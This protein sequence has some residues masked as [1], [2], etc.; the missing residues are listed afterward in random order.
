MGWKEPLT[1]ESDHEPLIAKLPPKQ[2]FIFL[3]FSWR[4]CLPPGLMT[5]EYSLQNHMIKG[6]SQPLK[7]V[8]WPLHTCM[9]IY[10]CVHTHTHALP[11]T[12]TYLNT[13]VNTHTRMYTHMYTHRHAHTHIHTQ[14]RTLLELHRLSWGCSSVGRSMKEIMGLISS[15]T[16][17]RCGST[18]Q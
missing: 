5:P 14:L 15:I 8:L 12:H 16:K 17:N 3:K 4:R 13:H 6:D 1:P 18:C 7:I 9:H 2:V 11:C 10:L